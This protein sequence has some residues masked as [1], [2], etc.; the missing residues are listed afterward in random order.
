MQLKKIITL[1]VAFCF[2]LISQFRTQATVSISYVLTALCPKVHL[3][4]SIN[5]I[6]P[7]T[8]ATTVCHALSGA[9]TYVSSSQSNKVTIKTGEELDFAF[10]VNGKSP[11]EIIVENLPDGITLT[12]SDSVRVGQLSGTVAAPGN[13]KISIKAYNKYYNAY[14]PTFELDLTVSESENSDDL[15]SF[16]FLESELTDLSHGW[17]NSTWFGSFFKS[18]SNWC[19]HYLHEWIFPVN[20]EGDSGF[21]FWKEDSGWIYAN[22]SAHPYYYRKSTSSWILFR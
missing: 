11:T 4:K 13:H 14:T 22:P 2:F 18:N 20:I 7:A 15:Y 21:W 10:T 16:P 5:C 17:K 1:R 3:A 8:A 6:I 19:Y 12:V 9:T